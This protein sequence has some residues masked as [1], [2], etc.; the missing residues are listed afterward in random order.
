[1]FEFFGSSVYI[2]SHL[3]MVGMIA[4]IEQLLFEWRMLPC[5][6]LFFLFAGVYLI[7]DLLGC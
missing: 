3:V 2:S 6:S 1:V 7:I 4:P 5:F